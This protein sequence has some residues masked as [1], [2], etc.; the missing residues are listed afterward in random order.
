MGIKSSK[1]REN[2]EG[3]PWAAHEVF[4]DV[5]LPNCFQNGVKSVSGE[6]R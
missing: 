6:V 3:K 4:F 5:S 1:P 2:C